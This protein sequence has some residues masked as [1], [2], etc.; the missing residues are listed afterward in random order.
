MSESADACL[1]SYDWPGNVRQL[2][3][4]AQRI[5]V[6]CPTRDID[7]EILEEYMPK[8]RP[9][10]PTVVQTDEDSDGHSYSDEREML[11]KVLFDMR[12]E[13]VEL[14]RMMR[15]MRRDDDISSDPYDIDDFYA[16][17]A[18]AHYE[19]ESSRRKGWSSTFI[20]TDYEDAY[21]EYRKGMPNRSK[22]GTKAD[23]AKEY[24]DISVRSDEKMIVE[25]FS[26]VSNERQLIVKALKATDG[27]RR[28]AAK[29]LGISERTLFRKIND[30]DIDI[31]E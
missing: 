9:F 17:S 25:D 4:T 23:D 3:Y 18:F 1:M 16:K 10:F 7:A 27:R 13:I 5:T 28:E 6:L 8:E 29:L 2:K 30:Y 15:E 22:Y 19:R 24:D 21:E 14:K 12:S 31:E 26:L 20:P 11:F